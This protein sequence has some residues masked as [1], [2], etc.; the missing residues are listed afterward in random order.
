MPLADLEFKGN[1]AYELRIGLVHENGTVK[2]FSYLYNFLN[3]KPIIEFGNRTELS[4][5]GWS[6]TSFSSEETSGEGATDGRA[7]NLID[8]DL[9]SYWHS[10]W[11]GTAAIYPHQ[12]VIDMGS[13]KSVEGVSM[14]QRNSLS[15]SVK[16]FEILYSNDGQSYVSAG[17]YILVN[18]G[19]VQYFKFSTKVSMRHL[20]IVAKSAHDGDKFAALAE[21]GAF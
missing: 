21:I 15:R 11:T 5:Q 18:S 13:L 7:V 1:T 2:S 4:K 9:N 17:N 8:G 10:K 3:D 16:D 12:V 14:V 19:S 20:K 6:I